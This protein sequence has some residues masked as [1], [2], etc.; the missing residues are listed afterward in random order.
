MQSWGAKNDEWIMKMQM[1]SAENGKLRMEKRQNN[2]EVRTKSTE[3]VTEVRM[4]NEKAENVIAVKIENDKT[5][6]FH[7]GE[8]GE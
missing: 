5:R 4:E 8:N 6:E 7:Q 2:T 3:N 1:I